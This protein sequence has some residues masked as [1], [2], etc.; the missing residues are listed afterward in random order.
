MKGEAEKPFFPPCRAEL[1]G[2]IQ[3]YFHARTGRI[4]GEHFDLSVLL[5]HK[6]PVCSVTSMS[7]ENG[8]DE[9]AAGKSAH[10]RRRLGKAARG[11]EDKHE[12]EKMTEGG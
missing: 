4:V 5:N 6:D 1:G 8:I 11:H 3:K 2:D 12:H 7:Q 10:K 9:A